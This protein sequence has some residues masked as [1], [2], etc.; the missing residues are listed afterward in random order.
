MLL[1][2]PDFRVTTIS[3]MELLQLIQAGG[4]TEN[5]HFAISN[6][7][8]VL[9]VPIVLQWVKNP[10]AMAQVAA[11]A[12][13]QSPAWYSRLKNPLL[14]L[15]LRFNLWPR[16]F[17]MLQVQPLKKLKKK[18]KKKLLTAIINGSQNRQDKG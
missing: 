3:F 17:H 6:K 10:T 9:G 11:E 4:M 14:Q 12:W 8:I 2:E 18:K 7:I 16:N 5:Y 1:Y 15:W 13:V